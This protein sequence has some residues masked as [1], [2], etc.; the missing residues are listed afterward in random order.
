M[1]DLRNGPD[2]GA[3]PGEFH[4]VTGCDVERCPRC[5]YIVN[6][7]DLDELETRW[8][9]VYT[10]GPTAKMQELFESAWG[11]R[12]LKWNGEW[13]DVEACREFGFWCLW[14][15]DMVPYRQGWVV[16]PAGTPGATESLNTLMEKTRWNPVTQKRELL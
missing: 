7:L 2:C 15:P 9:A 3:K 14:G 11:P 12:R 10:D 5:V 13:P 8:P 6:G 16:V 1:R 4:G